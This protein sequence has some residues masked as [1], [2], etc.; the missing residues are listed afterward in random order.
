[1]YSSADSLVYLYRRNPEWFPVVV[2]YVTARSMFEADISAHYISQQPRERATQ[3]IEFKRV[4]DKKRLDAWL[5]HSEH[6]NKGKREFV[7][8]VVSYELNSQEAIINKEY[9]AILPRFQFVNEK[10]KRKPYE[11]W[12]HLSFK[13]MAKAVDHEMEY[14]LF[15][16]DLSNFVHGN[17]ALA[18]RFLR[19][20]RDGLLWSVRAR[21]EDVGGVFRY[22]ATFFSCFLELYGR[23]FNLKLD[24]QI[25]SLWDSCATGLL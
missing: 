24:S 10:G 20:D 19:A 11:N 1:M 7:Q 13:N 4:L 23:Q 16:S 25:E 6:K 21:D 3:Y 8:S 12:A 5:R 14:D 2:G 18:D 15:Y 9:Q 17:I 22:V